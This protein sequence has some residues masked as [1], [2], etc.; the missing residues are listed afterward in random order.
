MN[1]AFASWQWTVNTAA[2]AEA[3]GK[4]HPGTHLLVCWQRANRPI[5]EASK[6]AFERVRGAFAHLTELDV[7]VYA[8]SVTSAIAQRTN[9]PPLAGKPLIVPYQVRPPNLRAPEFIARLDG[10]RKILSLRADKRASDRLE[11][12]LAAFQELPDA[13]MTERQWFDWLAQFFERG[14]ENPGALHALNVMRLLGLSETEAAAYARVITAMQLDKSGQPLH[15]TQGP[16]RWLG[17]FMTPVGGCFSDWANLN[18]AFNGPHCPP[19]ES[20]RLP[21][22][23]A[24]E[25]NTTLVEDFEW[26][27]ARCMQTARVGDY[28]GLCA[29]FIDLEYDDI[30]VESSVADDVKIY[31]QATADTKALVERFHSRAQWVIDPASRNSF[32]VLKAHEMLGK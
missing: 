6:A 23:I 3:Y 22:M 12:F 15:V 9:E 14:I 10:M 29:I 18:F 13:P 11:R 1:Y 16:V 19:Q 7:P 2:V 26:K 30:L 4:A 17:K 21:E 27:I 28:P 5:D 8:Y 25:G 31:A 20:S 24:D 32:E